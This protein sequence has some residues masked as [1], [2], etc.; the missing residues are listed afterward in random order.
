MSVVAN[1][2]VFSFAVKVAGHKE[3]TIEANPQLPSVTAQDVGREIYHGRHEVVRI[4]GDK[5]SLQ[6]IAWIFQ[7]VPDMFAVRFQHSS[8]IVRRASGW[9]GRQNLIKTTIS[10]AVRY[11]ATYLQ[12]KFFRKL[13]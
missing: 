3:V 12:S 1:P 6:K 10:L 7:R 5:N 9:R 13:F 4:V 8:L 11:F 2:R